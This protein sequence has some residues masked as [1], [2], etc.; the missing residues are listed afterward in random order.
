[1]YRQLATQHTV[2][3]IE[4]CSIVASEERR[5]LTVRM[6]TA[7]MW[8][9]IVHLAL[10]SAGLFT[11]NDLQAAHSNVSSRRVRAPQSTESLYRGRQRPLFA[12]R[13]QY[14]RQRIHVPKDKVAP[15]PLN[16]IPPPP[17]VTPK[18]MKP[19]CSSLTQSCLPQSGCCD[20]FATCHCRFF[21]AVCVCR[22]IK[23]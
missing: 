20:P 9:C 15:V 1:M 21:N 5:L 23:S 10:V 8:L 7:V 2:S 6:K 14:E 16:D 19:N 17:K 3:R 18:P 12:R 4:M 13:G 22:R 11:R